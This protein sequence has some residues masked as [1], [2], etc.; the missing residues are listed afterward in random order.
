[1]FRFQYEPSTLIHDVE[2]NGHS[3]QFDFEEGDYITYKNE[4]FCLKLIHFHEPSEH[5]I[6]GVI[7]PIEIHLVIISVFHII[8]FFQSLK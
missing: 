7:Y 6:D 5:K 2:N 1:M 3:I 4:R 8:C